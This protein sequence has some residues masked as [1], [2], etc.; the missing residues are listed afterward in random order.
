LITREEKNGPVRYGIIGTG[1]FNEDTARIY[2]DHHLF[3]TDKRLTREIDKV[4]DFFANNYNVPKFKH[5]VVSPFDTRKMLMKNIRNEIKNKLDGKEAYI[6]I[7]MN[8]LADAAIIRK[9][10]EASEA[11]VPILLFIRSMFSLIP[12]IDGLSSN[13]RAFSIVDKFLEHSRILVFCSGGEDKMYITSADL[14]PRNLDRRV[15]VTCPIYDPD[16]KQELRTFLRL[17]LEDNV[18]TRILDKDLANSYVPSEADKSSR[19]QWSI[20]DYLKRLSAP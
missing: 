2:S 5:F 15:E 4:F 3:T 9:L 17:Q 20:Y 16:L 8:N 10:Y 1:N 12:G 19:A 13:I 14:M 18:R 11:G 6:I 7:K